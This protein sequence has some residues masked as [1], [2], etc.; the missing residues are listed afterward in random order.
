MEFI[1][2]LMNYLSN[3]QV[4]RDQTISAIIRPMRRESLPDVVLAVSLFDFS[5]MTLS[6]SS[7][8][9]MTLWN[10]DKLLPKKGKPSTL[11]TPRNC[12]NPCWFNLQR[13]VIILGKTLQIT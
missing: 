9:S 1:F 11:H 3:S 5:N 6:F 4:T 2:S 8:S 13:T 12:G 7:R 10:R